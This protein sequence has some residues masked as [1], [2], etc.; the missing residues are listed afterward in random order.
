MTTP[1]PAPAPVPTPL[2]LGIAGAG[3]FAAFLLDAVADLPG[4]AVRVVADEV[5]GRAAALAAA[6]GGRPAT[7]WADLLTDD[8]VDVVVVATPPDS[9]ARIAIAALDAGRHVFCEKPLATTTDDAAAVVAAAERARR[10]L[11]VDHVLRYNPILRALLRLKGTLLGPVTRFNFENDASDENLP[12]DHWF[13]KERISGGIFVEHGVHFFDAANLLVG[14]L[15]TTVQ[16]SAVRRPGPHALIDLVSATC[17]HPG[18]VLAGHTHGF[19]HADR[20]ERQLMTIDHGCAQ[21]QVGGW[22][23]V[24]AAIDAWTDDTGAQEVE[25]LARGGVEL[26]AGGGFRLG[27]GAAVTARVWRDAGPGA[28]RGRGRRLAIPHHVRIGLTLGG[29]AAKTGVYRESVRAA[30]ADLVDDTAT[31][32]VP[33]SDGRHALSA[34]VV[35]DAARRAAAEGRTVVIGPTALPAGEPEAGD[36][37]TPGRPERIDKPWGFE[38]IFALVEGVYCGKLLHVRGGETLSLQYHHRKEETL[39]LLSAV[40]LD[41]GPTAED[42]HSVALAVGTSVHVRPGTLHRIRADTDSVLVEASS[43]APGWRTDVVR[44]DDRYGRSGTSAP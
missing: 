43:A 40:E 20:C 17:E 35:A 30:M 10:V 12:P 16:A 33:A 34:V 29:P 4:V 15:P 13:W 2:G 44:L 23:P 8:A 42:L 37:P 28:A 9:H 27:A 6:H 31:G 32:A 26:L 14:S 41:L 5:T 21:V 11:V 1:A 24:D 25:E 18:G 7:H 22:I 39:S 19:T 38:E 3:R 36:G